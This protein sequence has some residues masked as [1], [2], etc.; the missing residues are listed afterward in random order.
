MEDHQLC[1]TCYKRVI[2]YRGLLY[3]YKKRPK[4][5]PKP[6]IY[7]LCPTCAAYKDMENYFEWYRYHISDGWNTGTYTNCIVPCGY[8]MFAPRFYKE[9]VIDKRRNK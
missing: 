3:L 6:K 9:N 7:K 5:I 8:G 1:M 2:K 4:T